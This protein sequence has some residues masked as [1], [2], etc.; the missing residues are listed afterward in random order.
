MIQYEKWE[1]ITAP[2]PAPTIAPKTSDPVEM[3]LPI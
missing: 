2:D 3:S 1:I